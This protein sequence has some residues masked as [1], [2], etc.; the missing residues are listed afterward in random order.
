MEDEVA[1]DG[2]GQ[3]GRNGGGL[4]PGLADSCRI[5]AG[6]GSFRVQT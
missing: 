1:E 3:P 5:K 6:L 4:G 2:G